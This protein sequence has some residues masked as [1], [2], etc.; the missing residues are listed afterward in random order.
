[1]SAAGRILNPTAVFC[2]DRNKYYEMLSLA[3]KG[4]DE[5][6]EMWC[7]YVLSGIKNELGK[8]DK[9]TDYSYLLEKILIPAIERVYKRGHLSK[10]EADILNQ[11]SKEKIVKSSDLEA[12]VPSM[13]SRQRT[14]LIKKLVDNRML[15]PINE[16]A[17]QYHLQIS[18][19]LLL[20]SII[21]SLEES[22]FFVG[23]INE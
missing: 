7:T 23:D 6:L 15:S 2:N 16:K 14:F 9:L 5:N 11:V 4:E 10:I 17:R 1:M 13:S 3:D 22:D 18:N 21:Q 20:P 19:K 8:V 12:S